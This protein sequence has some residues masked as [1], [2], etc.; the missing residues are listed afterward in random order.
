VI[1]AARRAWVI[2]LGHLRLGPF[3]CVSFQRY[4]RPA[5]EVLHAPPASWGALPVALAV[6]GELIVPLADDE[7]VWLGLSTVRPEV[8][9]AFRVAAVQETLI[10]G[11]TGNA[12]STELQER[13]P[14]Y[15]QVPPVRSVDGVRRLDGLLPFV[16]RSRFGGYSALYLAAIPSR[17]P[18]APLHPAGLASLRTPAMDEPLN[19][20]PRPE[21]LHGS[22]HLERTVT[23][24]IQL[25]SYSSF[26]RRTNQQSPPPLDPKTIYKGWQLP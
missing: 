1:R 16:R 2:K 6:D 15:L 22:W 10:D 19:N 14:N 9:V 4:P 11:V 17:R 23:V 18:D 13:P 21:P 8:V 5:T 12:W 3:L 7:A 26:E 24:P 25:V 20:A